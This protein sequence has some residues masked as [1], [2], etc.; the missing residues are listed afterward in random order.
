MLMIY[1]CYIEELIRIEV[2]MTQE[3]KS[4]LLSI[5]KFVFAAALF[6]FVVFTLYRELSTINFKD[7]LMQFGKINRLW[8]VLLFAGGEHR[9]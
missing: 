9:Y 4:K 5:L 3:N 7:T 8:L 1:F 2:K 6:I